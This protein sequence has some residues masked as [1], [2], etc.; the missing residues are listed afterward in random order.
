MTVLYTEHIEE[1]GDALRWA[2]GSSDKYTETNKQKNNKQTNKNHDVE[3]SCTC[4]KMTNS[5][6]FRLVSLSQ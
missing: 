1:P 2:T 3:N 4:I 6:S 5:K